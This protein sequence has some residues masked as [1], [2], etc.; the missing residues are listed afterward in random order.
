MSKTYYSKKFGCT[1]LS[2]KHSNFSKEEFENRTDLR[3]S[4]NPKKSKDSWKI[5]INLKKI[6]KPFKPKNIFSSDKYPKSPDLILAN[7]MAIIHYNKAPSLQE[8][9][10]DIVKFIKKRKLKQQN[11]IDNIFNSTLINES[12]LFRSNLYI[13]QSENHLFKSNSTFNIKKAKTL[14]HPER[15]SNIKIKF[16]STSKNNEITGST[17]VDFHKYN[18]DSMINN[19][20]SETKNSFPLI[21]KEKSIPEIN[22]RKINHKQFYKNMY[23]DMKK[24]LARVK[25]CD[26]YSRIRQEINEAIFIQLKN[27]NDYSELGKKIMKFNVICNIR[28]N[29]LKKIMSKEEYNYDKRYD[30]LLKLKDVIEN[31][32]KSYIEEM[33]KYLN[34]LYF[35][36]KEDKEELYLYDKQIK[37]IDDELEIIIVEIVQ[38]Q[39]HLEYL[40]D[41]RNFLLLIKERFGNPPSYY[42]ELLVRDSKKLLVGDAI[43]NL[44]VTKL[45]KSKSIMLFNNSYLEVKEK[46]KQNLLNINNIKQ[47]SNKSIN[48]KPL[49][50]SVEEFIQLF[51]YLENKNLKYLKDEEIID[52]QIDRLKQ[53]YEEEK[54]LNNNYIEEEIEK[55]EK[56][57]E[58]LKQ[59]NLILERTYNHYK[60]IILKSTINKK[61]NNSYMKGKRISSIEIN[62]IKKYHEQLEKYKY[63]GFLLLN[64]LITLMKNLSNIKYD[65]S[66]FYAGILNDKIVKHIINLNINKFNKEKIALIN[67]YILLLI[68]KYEIICKYILNKNDIYSMNENNKEIIKDKT[69]QLLLDKKKQNSIELREIIKQKKIEEI[70]KIIEKSNKITAYIPNKVAP[71]STARRNKALKNIEEK[72]LAINKNNSLENEFNEL[73]HYSDDL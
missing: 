15:N 63:D 27:R 46:I 29:K 44:K 36:I 67:N 49:F 35:I 2:F 34:Y 73:V 58:K 53:Q 24:E 56:D 17:S 19:Y 57:L 48:E 41:R 71:E 54:L 20:N 18:V 16:S 33:D 65:K 12:K 43:Y 68:S 10:K 25:S 38:N 70:K 37:E 9:Q 39:T 50:G 21:I 45:I 30:K 26:D 66:N 4:K 60:E 13:T 8:N 47:P 59:K 22:S 72:I 61:N 6:K 14:F 42:E 11:E 62:N 31:T 23:S 1:G 32:Y 40:V 51:K 55:K 52:K 69:I 5:F 3:T 28:N 64:K 7:K